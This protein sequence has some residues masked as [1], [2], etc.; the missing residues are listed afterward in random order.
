MKTNQ[1]NSRAII[2][3]RSHLRYNK[4]ADWLHFLIERSRT[5][6]HN[7]IYGRQSVDKQ[8]S[9]SIESQ[10]ELFQYEVLKAIH[11]IRCSILSL[12]REL[13]NYYSIIRGMNLY[14]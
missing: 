2:A 8:D 12:E 7:A 14:G 3:L 5:L 4:C 1:N 9:I 11:S 10:V 13:N 6:A